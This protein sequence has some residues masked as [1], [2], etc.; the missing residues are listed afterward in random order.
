MNDLISKASVCEILA[1]IYPTD[2]ERVVPIERINK[3][4]EEIIQLPSVQLE[5]IR[6]EDCKYQNKGSNEV[7]AWN[8]CA[9]MTGTYIPISDD[10]F[11]NHGKRRTDI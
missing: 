7:D 10:D 2:G 9:F 1:D 3:A 11:C 5:I 4:Y 8:L 6:C